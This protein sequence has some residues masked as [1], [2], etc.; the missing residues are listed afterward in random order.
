MRLPAVSLRARVF[1]L[2]FVGLAGLAAVMGAYFYGRVEVDRAYARYASA[3]DALRTALTYRAGLNQ[4]AEMTE[5]FLVERQRNNAAAENAMLKETAAAAAD[6]APLGYPDAS[7]RLTAGLDE[8]TGLFGQIETQQ[9]ALGLH[10]QEGLESRMQAAADALERAIEDAE[11]QYALVTEFDPLRV[12]LLMLRR[13]ERDFLLLHDER[14]IPMF[15]KRRMELDFRIL[16]QQRIPEAEKPNFVKLLDGYQT[17]FQAWVEADKARQAAVVGFREKIATIRPLIDETVA[18]IEPLQSDAAAHFVATRQLTDRIIL[19]VGGGALALTLILGLITVRSITS[20]IARVTNLMRAIADGDL[21]FPAPRVRARDEI[22]ALCS[23]A[24]V[25]RE[26]MRQREAARLEE[27][28]SKRVAV[29][30]RRRTV[31]QVAFRLDEVVGSSLATLETRSR[32]L[33]DVAKT[34]AAGSRL[35]ETASVAAVTESEETSA[36]VESVASAVEELNAS[37]A[38]ISRRM[39]EASHIAAEA[40]VDAEQSSDRIASLAEAA[41]RIGEVV[42]LI[43]GIA[44]KTNLLAL[45]A[46]IEAAR[47]GEV[48]K[49]FAVVAHEVKTLATQTAHATEEIARQIGD[50]QQST[51]GAVGTIRSIAGLVAQVSE[52]TEAVVVAVHQ[53]SA[54]TSEISRNVHQ[55]VARTRAVAERLG[56]ISERATESAGAATSVERS[57]A[58]I[59]DHSL[60]LRSAV[61]QLLDEIRAAA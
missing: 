27:E 41:E 14:S 52:R 57:A 53:Q 5:R 32:T 13:D 17:N 48:G 21:D 58:D 37:I 42:R 19:G 9:T 24:D 6:L 16:E 8:A 15:N 18:V 61:V 1:L 12:K 44:A 11:Q 26:T 50:I 51:I 60:Q 7:E 55:T 56:D 3:G 54:A 49:G 35:T 34:M 30:E 38:E 23:V 31:E 36:N 47:A 59:S 39:D 43:S 29:E 40:R 46:T 25:F 2:L 28:E 45:N 33:D 22:G 20:P 10:G 4:L